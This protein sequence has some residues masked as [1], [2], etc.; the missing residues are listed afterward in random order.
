MVLGIPQVWSSRLLDGL[1]TS[2]LLGSAPRGNRIPCFPAMS[3]P[4]GGG[5]TSTIV[6]HLSS[7]WMYVCVYVRYVGRDGIPAARQTWCTWV[8][9]RTFQWEAYAGTRKV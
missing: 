2:P 1:P 7:Q 9:N 3:D 8:A 6:S 5:G 4:G